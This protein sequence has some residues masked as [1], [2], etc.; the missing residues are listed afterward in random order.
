M[1]FV[2]ICSLL[3]FAFPAAAQ[4]PTDSDQTYSTKIVLLF[5]AH[6]L[7]NE[8]YRLNL[9]SDIEDKLQGLLGN[10]AEFE[11]IDLMRKPNKDWTEQERNYLKTG[12]T[13]LDAPAP[14]SNEKLHV[15]W[16]EASEQGIRIRARQHDGSTGFNSLIREATLSDR[17]AI[18]KQITDWVIRDFGFTG[19]FIPAGDNVP[20]SWK[21]GRRGLALADWVRPGDVLKVVQIRKDGT[22]LRGTT[23]DCD[24]VLLQV[25]DEMKDGQ[26][27]C[28]LVRQYADRLPPARGSI[29]GYR[30][31][32]LATVTAPLK[33]KL[34]DPKG[35]PLR[36][37]GLQVRIKDSGFA[38]SYQERDLGVLFRDVFTSRDPMK[39]IA[40]VRIDLGERAIARI[41]LAITGDAVVVRTVNIE[42]GAESRDQLVAR[43]GFWLDRVN[44]SRRIQAQCFKDITQLVKQG[45]VDQADNSA[46]K[47]LSRIDGDISELTVDLQ[48]FKE[49]TIAA[50]VSLPGFTDVLDE[51]LQSLRDARRQLDS[52]IAQLDE[53]S[54]QQNLPEVVELKKKLNG[55]VLRIDSAIQQVNI[56]EALKLYDEAIVAAGTETAAKDAFTQKR[57]ELKKNWTPK[58]DAHSAARKFIYESWAKVQSFDDMKSKLPEARR[59]FD[60]CKDA[61]DKYGL[62]K[63]NQIGPELEQLLVDEIQ[64]LTDTPNKDES[65]LKRFDLMNAFKNEL[66]TFD[67]NVAAALRTFK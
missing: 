28:R 8:T 54:R 55:F 19:S 14:L 17:S 18:L 5:R 32:R 43:R 41:P 42:A 23:S 24:D 2:A 51:K 67:N 60:V 7:F 33:L 38:E 16:I 61:G 4:L 22:G 30:C 48:K 3:L 58:S 10:L 26:S 11:I 39:N 66:I 35:A 62:A 59:A 15:F 40:F 49:Q 63:L 52:Y 56:E 12:P 27:T 65:T 64:K 47:T 46:R 44:D 9:K 57:D 45:K 25:L 13:A 6:P 21:A 29:V 36:Q 53:V 31:I 50:K 34:I 1:R 37:V 20:V